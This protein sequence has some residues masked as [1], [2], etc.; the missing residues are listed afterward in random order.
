[1]YRRVA[2][3][4]AARLARA[5]RVP[6]AVPRAPGALR[7]LSGM[8]APPRAGAAAVRGMAAMPATL[9]PMPEILPALPPLPRTMR[10]PRRTGTMAYNRSPGAAAAEAGGA[11][12]VP[13]PNRPSRRPLLTE[14]MYAIVK[15]GGKQYR[16]EQGQSLL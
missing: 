13:G 5:L 4:G 6:S 2:G 3:A 9:P 7:A 14:V 15:T 12:L 8:A 11:A 16:V 10:R 1:M